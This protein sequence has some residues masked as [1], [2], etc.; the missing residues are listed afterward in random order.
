MKF[1]LATLGSRG[2]A[3]PYAAVG[4]ELQRRG[5]EVRMAVPPDYLGLSRRRGLLRSPTA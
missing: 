4:R 5:H 1:A 3:E 2:D